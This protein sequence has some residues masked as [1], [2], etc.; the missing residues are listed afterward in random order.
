M[1]GGQSYDFD[2]AHPRTDSEKWLELR[3]RFGTD[4]LVALWEADM[5]LR[6]PDPVVAALERRAREGIYGYVHKRASYDKAIAAWCAKHYGWRVDP[7]WVVHTP[8]LTTAIVA[9]LRL[10]TER[11]AGVVLP[12]PIYYPFFNLL[13][14]ADRTIIDTPMLWTGVRHELDLPAIEDAFAAG[15][16]V[17]V[18]VNPHNPGGTVWSRLE[19]ERV[20]ELCAR[21]GVR[22]ISDEAHADFAFAADHTPFASLGTDAARRSITLL[23]PSKTFNLAGL[24]QGVV[25]VPDPATRRLLTGE[26]ELLDLSKNN[27]FSLVAV[28]A[29]YRQGGPWLA[30]VRRYIEGSMDYVIDFIRARIPA[31]RVRKPEGTYL[32]WLD[33][34]GLGLAPAALQDFLVRRAGLAMASGTW[35]GAGGAGFQRLKRRL[36]AQHADRRAAAVEGAVLQLQ[37]SRRRR[38]TPTRGPGAS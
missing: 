37:E 14:D 27:V 8:T 15:A 3:R 13:R 33:C 12:T 11:G 18:L 30:Q 26:L 34:R 19:L 2:Q 16:Q 9:F 28:E 32:M 35:F 10:M 6:S 1:S 7:G 24:H 20:A 5:D 23:S 17:L 36:P 22:V 31:I 21:Y 29:G 38:E 4:G 25:V